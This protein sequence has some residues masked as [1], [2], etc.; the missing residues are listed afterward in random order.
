VDAPPWDEADGDGKP[1]RRRYSGDVYKQKLEKGDDPVVIA[2][3]LTLAI[4][5]AAELS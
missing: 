3:R 1:V 4:Q 2:K 5:S